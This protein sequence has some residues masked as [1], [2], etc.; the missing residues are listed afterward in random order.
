M[1]SHWEQLLVADAAA[2]RAR[3]Q[4]LAAA[5]G[6][7]YEATA[8]LLATQPDLLR[9]SEQRLTSAVRGL[10]RAL[11]GRGLDLLQLLPARPDL[12]SQAPGSLLAK[13]DA[14]PHA[15]QLPPPAVRH[16]VAVCPELLRRSSAAVAA[17]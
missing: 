14:L 1:A 2:L 17:R 13:L 6:Q 5:L 3:L 7:P 11:E 12:L 15:L 4:A 10:Q 8:Q 16:M 9:L